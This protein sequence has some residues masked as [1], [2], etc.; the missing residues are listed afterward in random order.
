MGRDVAP[1][2]KDS[3]ASNSPQL[4][5]GKT[6]CESERATEFVCRENLHKG[7]RVRPHAHSS[8]SPWTR[9]GPHLTKTMG[10]EGLCVDS[11]TGF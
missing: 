4:Y 5:E 1:A 10:A 3:Q 6:G 11:M 7:S 9:L 2:A 8:L